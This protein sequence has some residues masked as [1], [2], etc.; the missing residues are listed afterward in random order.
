MNAAQVRAWVE[1]LAKREQDL[2]FFI[3][4]GVAYTPKQ[5]LQQ[6]LS[7]T[8]IGTRLMALKESGKLSQLAGDQKSV[9]LLR[10]K[11]LLQSKLGQQKPLF[12]TLVN[13]VGPKAYTAAQL[14]DEINR[15]TPVG[16]QWINNEAGYMRKLLEVG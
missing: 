11:L 13:G 5:F 6:V 1:K 9:I 16:N 10:L 15:G 3:I 8:N 7:G 4:D 12:V 14:L 2:P